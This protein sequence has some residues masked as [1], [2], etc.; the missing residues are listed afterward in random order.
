MDVHSPH[1]SQN[2]QSQC[3]NNCI[4]VHLN[5]AGGSGKSHVMKHA[6]E[7][8]KQFFK[9]IGCP[10]T[11]KTICVT[12]LAGVS[13]T[14]MSGKTSH[15]AIGLMTNGAP[16]TNPT[17]KSKMTNEWQGTKLLTID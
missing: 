6:V 11:S 9:N 4:I 2:L 1:K 12:A 14:H 3:D 7:C 10:F 13:V 16:V 17:K 15:L 5:G 8:G